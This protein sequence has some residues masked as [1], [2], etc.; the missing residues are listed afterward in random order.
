MA[1]RQSSMIIL[2]EKS[3]EELEQE[4]QDCRGQAQL[5]LSRYEFLYVEEISERIRRIKQELLAL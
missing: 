2:S 5:A 4:L 3:R 1:P